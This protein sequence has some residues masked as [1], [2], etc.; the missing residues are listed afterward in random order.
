MADLDPAI[1]N[2]YRRG[3]ERDRLFGGFHS[4]PLEL[5]RTQELI[6][7]HLQGTGLRIADVGG[8]PGAYASWL[9]DRGHEVALLD[10]IELHVEQARE[11][12]LEASAG[13]A[14]ALPWPAESFDAVLMLGPLY[15]LQERDDRLAA[16]REA[17]RILRPGGLLFAAAVSRFAALLD[18]LV[19]L[20]NLHEEGVMDVVRTA[21]DTGKFHGAD[22]DLFTNAY[23]HYPEELLSEVEQV[24]FT[25]AQMFNIEGPGFLV[26][27]F[28]QRWADPLRR[29]ALLSAARLI[30]TESSMAG[31][32]SHMLAVAHRPE[33][34][35]LAG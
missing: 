35:D 8:G 13:D 22:R 7:R 26:S 24:G 1:A 14:R 5:A 17:H 30:E 18:M 20:D 11:V 4:G 9:A 27:D 31:A 33:S 29:Q 10:P 21:I 28:E 19:R 2:Y 12:G 23:F 25:A 3:H 15:H 16:L 34:A 6:D 32:S